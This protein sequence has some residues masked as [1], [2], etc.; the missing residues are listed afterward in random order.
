M[1]AG[2]TIRVKLTVKQKIKKEPR[3]DEQANGVVAWAIEV[4]NQHAKPVAVYDIMTLV[5]RRD[6]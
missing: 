5:A 2:D 3:G 6:A 1:A 4:T